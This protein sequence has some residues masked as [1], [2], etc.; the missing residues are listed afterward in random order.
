MDELRELYQQIILE[1]YRNPRNVGEL[2]D[3]THK[4]EGNNPLCGDCLEVALRIINDHIVDIRF[5]GKGC[6]ISQASAS[7]MTTLLKGKTVQEAD[8]LFE[9]F[10]RLVTVIESPSAQPWTLAAFAG[11]REFP[12]RVKCATL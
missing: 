5:R 6:A 8:E 2:P 1:H 4:A 7:V 3:A 11:I 10:H 12:S 9:R